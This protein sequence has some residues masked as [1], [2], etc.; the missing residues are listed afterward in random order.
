MYLFPQVYCEM[1]QRPAW[2]VIKHNYINRTEVKDAP[3][4]PDGL[5]YDIR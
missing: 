2:T 1:S 3:N 4:D 5:T